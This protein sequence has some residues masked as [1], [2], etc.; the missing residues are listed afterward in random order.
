LRTIGNLLETAS[1]VHQVGILLLYLLGLLQKSDWPLELLCLNGG[2]PYVCF[3]LRMEVV[4]NGIEIIL[5]FAEGLKI[6][7]LLLL[8]VYLNSKAAVHQRWWLFSRYSGW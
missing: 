7:L 6:L 1:C 4:Y 8:S 2:Y 3:K 5:P